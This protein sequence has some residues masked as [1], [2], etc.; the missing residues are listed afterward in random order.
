MARTFRE[1]VKENGKCG[2]E[3]RSEWVL[4]GDYEGNLLPKVCLRDAGHTGDHQYCFVIP[5][6]GYQSLSVRVADGTAARRSEGAKAGWE[7]RRAKELKSAEWTEE[8][9]PSFC[10]GC[11][12]EVTLEPVFSCGRCRDLFCAECLDEWRECGAC[13]ERIAPA[14]TARTCARQKAEQP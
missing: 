13:R 1:W 2:R 6:D 4:L 14:P 3:G 11:G 8:D 12:S 5:Q 7:I 10:P 9:E